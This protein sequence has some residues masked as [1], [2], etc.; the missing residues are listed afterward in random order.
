MRNPATYRRGAAALCLV[1]AGVLSATFIVLAAAPGWG[2]DGV[3][4]LQAVA[5]AGGRA[6]ASFLAF[7]T[8]QLPLMIG[9]LGVAHLLRGRT[10]LLANLGGTL[11]AVG[12]I[13][14]AVYGGSQLIIP[15][16]VADQANLELFAQLR[17]DAEPLTEPFAAL[18]M[19]GSVVGLLLLSIALWR[20]K[21]GP[22]WIPVTLWVFFA[23]EF[24]GTAISPAAGPVSAALLLVALVSLGV[25]VQ[26]SPVSAWTSA[27]DM[28]S[29]VQHSNDRR[30]AGTAG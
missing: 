7:V 14:Y 15:A 26:R 22:R 5:D 17:A 21:L 27:V 3:A 25:L 2:S 20:A 23:V 9:L 30:G 12:A 24:V 11:A 18:G 10:P 19:V 8:Y 16:M 28:P 29:P 4:R 13:G 1:L 6:T